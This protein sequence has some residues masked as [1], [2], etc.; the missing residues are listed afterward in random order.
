MKKLFLLSLLAVLTANPNAYADTFYRETFNFCETPT[1]RPSAATVA[2]WR[3]LTTGH[4]E[5]KPSILKIQPVGA[6]T[7]LP[8]VAS[9]AE[10]PEDGNGYWGRTDVTRGLLLFTEEINFPIS[11]LYRVIWRQRVDR[12]AKQYAN[13]GARVA[14]LIGG[15]WYISD[16]PEMQEIRGR[17]ER[18][19]LSPYSVT[20]GTVTH[21]PGVGIA[22]PTNAGVAL[23]AQGTVTAVG[24]FFIRSYAKVRIDDF[25]LVNRAPAGTN[26]PE[27]SY[28]RCQ[29]GPND[30]NTGTD[31]P[32]IDP[33]DV[34][35]DPDPT[36][37]AECEDGIDNDSD[38]LIDL[39]DPGCKSPKDTFE[40]GGVPPGSPTALQASDGTSTTEVTISWNATPGATNYRLYR[41]QFSPQSG[42][43][44]AANIT[45]T[46]WHDLSAVPG[47]TYSYYVTALNEYEDESIRSNVD[48]GFRSSPVPDSDGDGIL[49][50]QEELD[51][52]D[53]ND[54]GSFQLHLTSP[55]F[56]KYN[57]Y[58]GQLNFLELGASGTKAIAATVRVRL[59]SGAVIATQSVVVAAK[60]QFDVNINALLGAG[61]AATPA[62]CADLVDHN[63]D[64]LVDTYGIV[65]IDFNDFT[66]DPGASL[67]GRMSNYRPNAPSHNR[68]YS[69]A[70][71]KEL[72]NPSHGVAFA[73]AN[74]FDPQNQGYSVPNWMEISNLDPLPRAFDFLLWS[75]SGELVK[76]TTVTVPPFGERDLPAGHE[77]I[78]RRGRIKEGVYLAEIRPHEGATNYFSTLSRYSSN[79]APGYEPETYN[80]AFALD[81]LSGNGS[82]HL[83]PIA[84]RVGQCYS[85]SNWLEITNVRESG[86]IA[87]VVFRRDDGSQLNTAQ[88]WLAPKSQYH[89][90]ASAL[91]E[92]GA[93]GSAEVDGSE[94]GSL[95][96]QSLVYYHDCQRNRLQTAYAVQ[97]RM[98]GRD[99]QQGGVNTFLGMRNELYILSGGVTNAQVRATLTSFDPSASGG[100]SILSLNPFAS[101]VFTIPEVGVLSI[102][103]DHYGALTLQGPS[104]AGFMAGVLRIRE[105]KDGIVEFVMPTTV[106]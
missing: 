105:N 86:V 91:L 26:L 95:I 20:Y 50:T 83:A 33:E 99:L 96:T 13:Y 82:K 31:D 30:P 58:L 15:T 51:G 42:D 79:A 74:T 7:R 32:Y 97:A 40:A 38:G 85:Q 23:P 36:P 87:N 3:A 2:G 65:Q 106:Q 103:A 48:S 84:N 88:I 100:S 21:T 61:C 22:A 18:K 25:S 37:K 28:S 10:G 63:G 49:D 90:N 72:R 67:S 104:T 24:L 66:T 70:F 60:T 98:V 56:T 4:A 39:G 19:E 62:L 76:S 6:A 29:F 55:A 89:F 9:N 11:E 68:A 16:R 43:L 1:G 47:V 94:A 101:T 59:L 45:E 93:H 78:D 35:Q 17:Y 53:K 80:Y 8:S 102:P 46:R 64:G 75:Q 52:T 77:L 14:F 34:D 73:T 41:S 57:T 92:R 54:P 27:R 71:A 5:G 12:Q 69:F 81:A 44:I